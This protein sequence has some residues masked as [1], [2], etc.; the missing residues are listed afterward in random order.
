MSVTEPPTIDFSACSVAKP[1]RRKKPTRL[2]EAAEE[3]LESMAP[4]QLSELM[5]SSYEGEKN[6]KKRS[7]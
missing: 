7:K 6:E 2:E 4:E 5:R 3:D 1:K